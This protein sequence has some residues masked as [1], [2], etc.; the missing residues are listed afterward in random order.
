MDTVK[1]TKSRRDR[2]GMNIIAIF[3][4]SLS[5]AATWIGFTAMSAVRALILRCKLL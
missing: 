3:E 1:L 5:L 4:A 2:S